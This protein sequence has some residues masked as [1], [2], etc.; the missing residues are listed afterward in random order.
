MEFFKATTTIDF[1]KFRSKALVFSTVLIIG[2]LIS[3]FFP[4]PNL[5]VDFAGGTEV[6]LQLKGDVSAG[7]LRDAVIALGHDSPEIVAVQGQKNRYV[8]RVKEDANHADKQTATI[9]A[10]LASGIGN[11]KVTD[12]KLTGGANR[13][14]LTVTEAVTPAG[15]GT[16]FLPIRDIGSL[17]KMSGA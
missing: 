3:L 6:E 13:L 2:T 11:A 15:T 5:G 4:G 17:L 8:L 9:K 10:K 7:E 14:V 12:I 16:G 1:L